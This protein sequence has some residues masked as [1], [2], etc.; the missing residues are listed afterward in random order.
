MV[1]ELELSSA[2][3]QHIEKTFLDY[4]LQ[5]IDLRADLEREE[6][7]L[8]P[9][10]EADEVDLA[11]AG[12]QIEKV[13]AARGKLEK[14]NTMMLLTIRK[15]L[16]VAQWNKLREIEQRHRMSPPPL[17][18]PRPEGTPPPPKPHRELPR[19]GS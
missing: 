16:T 1:A 11:R 4:R 6:A 10:I 18:P 14:T 12:G 15:S 2:Q 13:I 5:L 19:R 17:G 9:I 7:R 8:E 3:V